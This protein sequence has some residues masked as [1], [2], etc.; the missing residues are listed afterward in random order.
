VCGKIGRWLDLG[1]A[2]LWQL[3]L[4]PTEVASAACYEADAFDVIPT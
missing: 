4:T 2:S 1:L 3:K